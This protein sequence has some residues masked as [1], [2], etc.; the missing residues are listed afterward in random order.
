MI[1]GRGG[2]LTKQRLKYNSKCLSEGDS[3]VPHP[4]LSED[5][6]A[7]N[8]LCT[9]VLQHR[10]GMNIFYVVLSLLVVLICAPFITCLF[11]EHHILSLTIKCTVI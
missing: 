9:A 6:S 1:N 8:S 5:V 4:Y 2:G 3:F 10:L 7:K 11:E